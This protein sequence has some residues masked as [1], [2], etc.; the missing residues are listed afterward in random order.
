MK[1]SKPYP[2]LYRDSDRHGRVRWRLRAP[3][4]KTV[5]I[6]GQYGSPEF[7]ANYRSA[8]EGSPVEPKGFSPSMAAWLRSLNLISAP[9]TLP[10][11][12]QPHKELSAN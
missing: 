8:F 6:K 5:T 3:G 4:R 11:S 1:I 12:R 9:P 10:R 7:A 2:Y